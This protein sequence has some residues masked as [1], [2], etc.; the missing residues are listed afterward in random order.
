MKL[1][2]P[3]ILALIVVRLW[4]MPLGSSFWLDEMVTVFVVH[5]GAGHASLKIAPQ[6]SESIY[7]V[8]AGAFARIFGSSEIAYRGVSV[9][10]MGATL[11]FVFRLAMRLINPQA[12]WFAVVACLA[13]RGIDYQ[14][15]D[16][17]PYAFGTCVAACSLWLLVRWLDSGRFWD[18]LYFVAVAS[19]LW[20]IHLIYWPFYAIYVG[21]TIS[22]LLRGETRVGM[23]QAVLFFALM[24]VFLVPVATSALALYDQAG[25]HVVAAAPSFRDLINALK[26]GLVAGTWTIAFVL[27]R[28]QR[29]PQNERSAGSR[30]ALLLVVG[31]WLC[32]PL[33]LFAFSWITGNSVFVPRYLFIALPGAALM[34]TMAAAPFLPLALWRPVSL[35]LGVGVL[36][37]LGQWS[38]VWPV[39]QNSDWRGAAAGIQRLGI[40]ELPVICPSP[41]IEA[42]APAWS[43]SY[44]LPGFLYAH[45]SVYPISGRIYPFP[46]D[47]S[48]EAE[49]Y[50]AQLTR[51]TLAGSKRFLIYGWNQNVWF[52]RDW[53]AARPELSGWSQRRLGAFGDVE[54]ILFEIGDGALQSQSSQSKPVFERTAPAVF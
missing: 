3:S 5:N 31:W 28:W 21:Y 19:L 53:F 20:R 16:A 9:L 2:L 4:L 29:W 50:A 36:V 41:F 10:A 40:P 25:A 51:E 32:Q 48:P 15:S 24:V 54:A 49:S 37:V 1:L 47:T 42:R 17:R 6:V 11:Y 38:R 45:L 14:A 52:W 7:Y 12:G 39:H 22:R 18:G 44:P 26:L 23:R 33:C 30:S 43:P 35:V 46:F 27:V 34:A 8:V 13:L